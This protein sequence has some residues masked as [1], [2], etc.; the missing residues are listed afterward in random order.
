VAPGCQPDRAKIQPPVIPPTLN[1]ACCNQ[2][3]GGC[4][5]VTSSNCLALGAGYQYSGDGS[6]C[7]P[8]PCTPTPPPA[9][10][11][12]TGQITTLGDG[13]VKTTSGAIITVPKYAVTQTLA[14]GE[15]KMTFSIER[16][17]AITVAPPSG[18]TKSSDVYRF[19]PDGFIFG[20]PV[21]LTIPVLGDTTNK[22]LALYRFNQTTGKAE[23]YGGVFDRTTK[24]I[25]V[26]TYKLSPWF[27]GS[28]PAANTAWGAIDVTNG[29]TDQWL[30][31]CV[32]QYQLKYPDADV[33]FHGEASSSWAPFGEI[34]VT[35]RGLWFVPQGTYRICAEMRRAGTISTPPGPAHHVLLDNIVVDAPWTHSQPVTTPLSLTG[36]GDSAQ[37]ST[38]ACT[39]V[40]TPSVG[41]GDV[42]VT[43]TWHSAQPIDLDL[44]VTEPDSTRCY[45]GHTVTSTGG[46]LDIDNKCG[47]YID[48]RPENIFWANAPRGEY[49]VEVDWYSDCS[50]GATSLGY[51]LRVINGGTVRT[52]SGT[53]AAGAT[54]EACRFTVAAGRPGRFLPVETGPSPARGPRPAKE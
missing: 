44:W 19:G 43:L 50:T 3:N 23:P 1:G 18:S 53:I 51:D 8:N 31:L 33:D 54:I 11:V 39:P 34:G 46:S 36:L 37:D 26:Q 17:Q 42:Q 10:Y 28:A 30:N 4:A 7:A 29:T 35:N 27:V 48:G 20:R 25:S 41:T 52:F 21:K 49:K 22:S 2:Q 45:Y 16:D 5:I 24:T 9:D 14:G 13:E 15:G 40:A 38:C 12:A 6:A 47:D 32:E